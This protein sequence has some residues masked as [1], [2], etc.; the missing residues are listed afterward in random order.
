MLQFWNIAVNAFME[1]IRQRTV[2]LL[3]TAS[4]VFEVF[5]AMPHYFAFGDE[6]NCPKASAMA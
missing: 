1:L 5:L 6:M 4:V 2:L 3:M